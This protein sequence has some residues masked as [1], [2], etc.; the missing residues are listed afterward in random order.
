MGANVVCGTCA[1]DPRRQR[2][3]PVVRRPSGAPV[4]LGGAKLRL[5][6]AVLI[7]HRRSPLTP[8]QMCDALWP[9][10]PPR[11]ATRPC[12]ATSPACAGCSWPRRPSS[13]TNHG[14]SWSPRPARRRRPVRAGDRRRLRCA[15]GRVREVDARAGAVVVARPGVRRPGRQDW[16]RPE[17]VRLDELRLSA[18]ERWIEAP[19]CCGRGPRA[20]RRPRTARRRAPAARALLAPADARPV[21]LGSAGRGAAPGHRAARMRR[22]ELGLDPSPEARA[23]E[24]QMLADD[25]SLRAVPRTVRRPRGVVV[26]VPTRL[27]GRDDDLARLVRAARRRAPRH[28][29]RTGRGRQDA[30]GASPRGHRSASGGTATMVE[31]TAVRDEEAV[32]ATVA[33]AL[34]VAAS[35]PHAGDGGSTSSSPTAT[36]L[37]LDN[38]EHVI[39]S[40]RI[41]GRPSRRR[42]PATD[43]SGHLAR[44]ARR[45]PARSSTP[46]C[47]SLPVAGRVPTMPT[48]AASPAVQ[49]FVRAGRGGADPGSSSTAANRCRRWPEICRRLDGLPLAIELAA[50]RCAR[51]GWRRCSNDST[52]ASACSTPGRARRRPAPPEPPRHRRLVLRPADPAEQ[53]PVRPALGLRRQ[54]RPARRRRRVHG[55]RR[56][57]PICS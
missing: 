2:V 22:N 35:G 56:P 6:L 18:T 29:D 12:R 40:G 46:S 21:P 44:A 48:L 30:S 31:L 7:A 55:R 15:A 42:V 34:D 9:Q 17:A 14:T 57:R 43:A 33:R 23:L 5:L 25:P 50:A 47:R 37:V 1:C 53:K 11:S 19:P 45:C 49:L 8:D 54:L 3:G 41:P 39:D 32:A 16:I 27:V 10:E 13:S 26:D 28:A 24:R 38:C 4:E 36:L 51:S 52:S 20:G